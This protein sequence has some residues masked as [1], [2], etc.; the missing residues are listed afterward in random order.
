MAVGASIVAGLGVAAVAG[1]LAGV[2]RIR[3]RVAER[4]SLRRHP[5]GADGIIPGAEGFTLPR[6][7]GAAVLLLHGMGDTPGALRYLAEALH[8]RG[9][10]VHVPLLP[11]HGRTIRAFA[12]VSAQEWLDAASAS[13]GELSERHAWVAVAGLS[14]GG[15]LAVRLAADPTLGAAVRALVL[16]AP[17]LE[18][19]PFLRRADRYSRLWG[20]LG[21]YVNS[22]DPRSIRDEAER[23]RSLGYGIITPAALRALLR[24]ADAA[25]AALPAVSAPTLMIQSRLD[26]RILAAAAERAFARLG[27][28]DKRLVWRDVGGHIV[29]VDHGREEVIALVGA[30]LDERRGQLP[31]EAAPVVA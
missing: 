4:R 15:A 30:W 8:A 27:A 12:Q 20:M 26:N 6:E 31:M 19:K 9:Y 21:T 10:A 18:P 24:T 25:S 14:M 28:R 1:A 22:H 7:G 16:L 3:D 17:Y 13:L 11:G 5:V 2:R 23:A 29:T